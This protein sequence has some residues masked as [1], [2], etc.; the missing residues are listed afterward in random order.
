MVS[1]NQHSNNYIKCKW[2][3]YSN[4][5]QEVFRLNTEAE[6]SYI[7]LGEVFKYK[8]PDIFKIY[9][10]QTLVIRKLETLT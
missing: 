10:K 5:K 6:T 2:P 8:D 4:L 7:C 1:S 9:V 3:K